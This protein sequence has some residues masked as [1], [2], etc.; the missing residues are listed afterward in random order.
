LEW[1]LIQVNFLLQFT[2]II[3]LHLKTSFINF[4]MD[5]T[6]VNYCLLHLLLLSACLYLQPLS[7]ISHWNHTFFVESV[8]NSFILNA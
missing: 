2:L 5:V 4:L 3:L 7:P 1:K 6:V 8:F